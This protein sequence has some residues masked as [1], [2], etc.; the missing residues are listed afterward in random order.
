M[1]NNKDNDRKAIA[2]SYLKSLDKGGISPTTGL[3]LFDHFNADA[4]VYFPKWGVAKGIE[5]IKKLFGDVGS[6]LKAITHHYDTFNWY[7]TGDDQFAVEGTSNGLHRD[8]PWDAGKPAWGS[9]R[10]CDTFQLRNNKI[11][12]LYIYL[13]PDYA[14]L[15]HKRYEWIVQK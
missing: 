9:G 4:E 8:G 1:Q 2:E 10:W 5:E 11:Q 6:T 13:D 12:R 14:G 3:G 15:D 7:M